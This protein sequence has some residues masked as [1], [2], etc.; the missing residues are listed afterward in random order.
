MTQDIC[1]KCQ[2]RPTSGGTFGQAGTNPDGTTFSV[3]LGTR[4]QCKENHR[5]EFDL[6]GK[7]TVLPDPELTPEFVQE[8][9]PVFDE[10]SSLNGI[11]CDGRSRFDVLREELPKCKTKREVLM[12]L[13]REEFDRRYPILPD[14]PE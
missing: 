14:L 9:V 5:W 10:W 4:Y 1:P 11:I 12:W 8:R 2:G 3:E 6:D 13:R 7:L